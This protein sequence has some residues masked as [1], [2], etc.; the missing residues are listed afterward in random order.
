MPKPR[1]TNTQLVREIMN[2]SEHGPLIQA[3]VLEALRSYSE[4]ILQNDLPENGFIAPEL[5]KG[6]AQ[7][8]I[9]KLDAHFLEKHD[10]Q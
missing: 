5:W 2:Y 9:N 4:M 10:G 3:F 6:C 7:E 8:V 1:M